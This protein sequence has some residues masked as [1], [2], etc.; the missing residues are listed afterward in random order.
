MPFYILTNTL[1][2]REGL[3]SMGLSG[4]LSIFILKKSKHRIPRRT[5]PQPSQ[6]QRWGWRVFSSRESQTGSL[7]PPP[8]PQTDSAWSP[9]KFPQHFLFPRIEP[10][11]KGFHL[12][13]LDSNSISIVHLD[14]TEP[15]ETNAPPWQVFLAGCNNT[16]V[17]V[18]KFW[19]IFQC[20]K[21]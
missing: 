7:P 11:W 10:F 18:N 17:W 21:S 13:R 5:W 6:E 3:T 2:E 15:V 16:K 19:V 20:L 14:P 1:D 9:T 4:L 12:R 8:P